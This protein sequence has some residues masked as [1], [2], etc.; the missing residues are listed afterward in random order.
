MVNNFKRKAMGLFPC[1]MGGG[2]GGGGGGDGGAAAREAARQAAISQ[3]MENLNQQFAGFDDNYYGGVKKAYSDKNIPLLDEQEK[4]ARLN[5]PTSMGNTQ[6]SEYA[7]LLERFE[8]DAQRARVEQAAQ[9]DQFAN[10]QRQSVEQQ[11]GS[12]A[13]QITAG[14][15]PDNA[16]VLASGAAKTLN[17]TPLPPA[18]GDIF[19]QYMGNAGNGAYG[20]GMQ[21]NPQ[22]YTPINFASSGKGS[23]RVVG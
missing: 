7:R 19:A 5:L 3:G 4:R 1:F 15:S 16:A 23:Q 18:I 13:S 21:L 12:I 6:N 2:G 17:A 9:A 10:S 20:T 8:T 22:T 11:R 14:A